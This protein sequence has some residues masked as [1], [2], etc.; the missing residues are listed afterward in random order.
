[1]YKGLIDNLAFV[2]SFVC[3]ARGKVQQEDL[4]AV[5]TGAR[6]MTKHAPAVLGREDQAEAA[7]DRADLAEA[8]K[9]V[10]HIDEMVVFLQSLEIV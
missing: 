1:M 5:A 4:E 2:Y 7:D 8:G 10:E 6:T 3:K 9:I